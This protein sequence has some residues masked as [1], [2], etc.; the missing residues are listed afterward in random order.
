MATEVMHGS[1][2]ACIIPTSVVGVVE[3]ADGGGDRPVILVLIMMMMIMMWWGNVIAHWPGGSYGNP[4]PAHCTPHIAPRALG[5]QILFLLPL[6]IDVFIIM[7]DVK[8]AKAMMFKRKKSQ[9]S[10]VPEDCCQL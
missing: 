1:G 8:A 7:T 4:H 3:A 6:N 9:G 5:R 2:G 10:R